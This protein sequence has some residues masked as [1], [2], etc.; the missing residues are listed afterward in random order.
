MDCFSDS[1][2][3]LH[4]SSLLIVI[5]TSPH[6]PSPLKIHTLSC[7]WLFGLFPVILISKRNLRYHT[8]TSQHT[9][10]FL[11]TPTSTCAR[12]WQPHTQFLWQEEEATSRVT[13]SNY[14]L[15]KG[16]SRSE[17]V[18]EMSTTQP[19][20]DTWPASLEPVS[21]WLW[22]RRISWSQA[23]LMLLLR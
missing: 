6:L 1:I 21:D 19:R 7:V 9:R 10:T 3:L 16:M 2:T 5:L 14:F 15:K 4:T 23:H 12:Q 20:L 17:Q 18:C 8:H 13:S 22:L 11:T